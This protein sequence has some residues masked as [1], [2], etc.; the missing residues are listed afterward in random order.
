MIRVGLALLA[1]MALALLA[2]AA[3]GE[4]GILTAEW[5]GW[6]LDTSAAAGA[7]LT[8]M[9]ALLAVGFWRL[10]IWIGEAPHRAALQRLATRRRDS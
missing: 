5:L 6:R 10:V 9:L 1:G 8:G 4:P 3:S 7:V 2:V